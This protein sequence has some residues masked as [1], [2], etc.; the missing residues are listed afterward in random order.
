MAYEF[1]CQREPVRFRNEDS[2][3]LMMIALA[4]P[5]AW[6]REAVGNELGAYVALLGV[7]PSH[8]TSHSSVWKFHWNLVN[9]NINNC[10]RWNFVIEIS[11]RLSIISGAKVDILVHAAYILIDAKQYGMSYEFV[12]QLEPVRSRNQ[13][14]KQM[15][16]LATP[17]L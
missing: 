16:A 3:K 12:C 13:F 10:D 4:F 14:F 2:F 5:Q 7:S 11:L 8:S 15:I 6:T 1:A 9:E 17:Q